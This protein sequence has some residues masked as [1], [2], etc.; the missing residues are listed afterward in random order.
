MSKFIDLT[1]RERIEGAPG[2][3]QALDLPVTINTEQI[4]LFNKG[5][6]PELTFV[7]MS[8]GA[9]LCVVMPVHELMEK[10]GLTVTVKKDKKCNN[11]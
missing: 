3:M 5:E 2:F 7:R 11:T 10:M 1:I 8:C 6:D 9:T 4:T